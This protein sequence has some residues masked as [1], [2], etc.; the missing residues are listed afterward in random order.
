MTDAGRFERLERLRATRRAEVEVNLRRAGEAASRQEEEALRRRCAYERELER[1]KASDH[2]DAP[3]WLARRLE[4]D[5]ELAGSRRARATA[6]GLERQRLR[7]LAALV[8]ARM[9]EEKMAHL[10]ARA[11]TARAVEDRRDEARRLDEVAQRRREF[12]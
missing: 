4:L 1:F 5:E 3:L 7:L 2:L 6:V 9:D 12:R 10:A 8:A 11:R